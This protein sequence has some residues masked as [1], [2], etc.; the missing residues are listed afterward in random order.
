MSELDEMNCDEMADLAAEL[1]LGVL[2]GRERAQ[3]IAHLDR[4]D[5]CRENVRQL[6]ETGEGLLGLLPSSE[7]PAGFESRVTARLEAAGQHRAQPGPGQPRPKLTRPKLTRPKL[8]RRMLTTA[9]VVLAAAAAGLGGWGLRGT[10]P[11]PST[12]S[13]STTQSMLHA[14]ALTTASHRTIGKIFLYDGSPGWLYMN[15]DTGSGNGA[16][17]CQLEGRDGSVITIGS[18]W[19]T[20]GYGHWGSP[21]PLPPGAVTGARLTTADGEALATASF[22]P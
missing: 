22:S 9:A 7:P 5:A 10:A 6:T 11:A 13:S 3:A 12:T 15:V 20:G 17:V 21:E 19:L 18:F 16:V 8:T 14:A 4:C 1:A 2:T